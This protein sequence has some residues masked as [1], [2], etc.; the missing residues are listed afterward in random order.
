MQLHR[1]C[2]KA[3]NLQMRM[4]KYHFYILM[5]LASIMENNYAFIG[6]D[7]KFPINSIRIFNAYG[8]RVS[9]NQGYGA[10]FSVFLKQKLKINH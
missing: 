5:L 9:F 2:G 7:Y 1:R 10:A 6:I 3:K 8:N 4:K